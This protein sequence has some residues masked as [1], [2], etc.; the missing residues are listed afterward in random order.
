LISLLGPYSNIPKSTV[1]ILGIALGL[2]LAT[3]LVNKFLVDME[4][5]KQ[6]RKDIADWRKELEK[7]RKSGDRKRVERAMKRQAAIT[8]LQ[9]RMAL[10]Q[11]KVSFVFFV[12]FLAIF[13]LLSSFF[14]ASVVAY[15]PFE[16]PFLMGKELQ[17]VSWYILAS[18][19][20]SLPLAKLLK[21]TPE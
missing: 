5:L 11:M 7:A 12:P 3:N 20:T 2:S 1:L 10:E 21:T 18:F 16:V 9:G 4:K 19:A 15:S 6:A 14:G 13:T 17:F 8:K